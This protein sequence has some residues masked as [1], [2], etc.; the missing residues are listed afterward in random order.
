M[1]ALIYRIVSETAWAASRQNSRYQGEAHDKADGFIHFSA[2]HQVRETAA[3]H[4][5]GRTGL[6][7]LA[8]G[9]EALG[10]ALRWEKSRGSDL[11]PHLYGDLYTSHVTWAAPLPLD[12]NGRHVFPEAV[13]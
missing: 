13:S 9:A 7:L 12:E 6:I 8:V 5:E 11:F 1:P 2:A 4:Y 3:K 10:D